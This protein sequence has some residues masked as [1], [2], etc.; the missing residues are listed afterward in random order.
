MLVL[1]PMAEAALA[2]GELI[3]AK[4]SV[5]KVI[6]LRTGWALSVALTTRARIAVLRG[7][8]EQAAR[9][10]AHE[11]LAQATVV[12]AYLSTP[13]ILECVAG[14]AAG[15]D[16]QREAARLFGAADAIRQRTGQV[17]LKIYDCD[18]PSFSGR[19][20]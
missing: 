15:A 11:A 20:A 7:E 13:D 1:V 5:D 12:E 17:R 2:R 18:L 10:D 3:A 6:S 16:S 9:D 14:L 19:P 4:R 8:P